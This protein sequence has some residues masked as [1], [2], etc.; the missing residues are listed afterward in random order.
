MKRASNRTRWLL[1]GLL[2]AVLLAVESTAVYFLFT[3]RFPSGNDF[4][5]RWAGGRALL[6]EGRDPYSLEVTAEIQ[7]AKGIDPSLEGKGSFAYPLYVLLAFWPLVYLPYA[8]AQAVWMVILQW[9]TLGLVAVLIR[10]EGW[11]PS[12][13]TLAGLFVG[14]LFLYPV[15]RSILLGQ[16]TLHVTLFLAL[17]LWFLQSGRDGWAG[18]C[19]AATSIKPQMLILVAPWLLVWTITRR[20]WRFLGGLVLAGS[21]LLLG[22]LAL[23]PS[24]PVSFI[25][26]LRRYSA[27]AG[28]RNP[29]DVLL[30]L[31]WP[32]GIEAARYALAGL[33]FLAMLITW[34]RAHRGGRRSFD[35]AVQWS[36][37]VGLLVPFQTGST[38]Q[39]LLLIPFFAWLHAASESAREA[40]G[41]GEAARPRW[42]SAAMI[43]VVAS[44]ELSLWIL[45]LSTVEGNLEHPVMFLPL[46]L[47]SLTVLITLEVYQ[48]RSR[49]YAAR[50]SA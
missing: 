6:V 36:I 19:L 37:V 27:V 1:L 41:M 11:R 46:P 38:N 7:I 33:L 12:P 35:R 28:G 30:G 2:F 47:L 17:S 49:V 8:W 22:S 20:R 15:A 39:V 45:F 40:A 18:A 9:L 4:Y 14:T 21:L 32:D 34:W 44:L 43:A 16:F 23:F 3:S 10:L 25:E 5:S 24:W 29:L 42:R 50:R 13:L 31:V 26:D 48:W